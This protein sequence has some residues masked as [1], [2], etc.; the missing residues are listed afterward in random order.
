MYA[1]N[2]LRYFCTLISKFIWQSNC[3]D[4]NHTC[5]KTS[6]NN[7]L[8]INHNNGYVH[9][10]NT[11]SHQDDLISIW[12]LVTDQTPNVC[13]SFL[14]CKDEINSIAR[15]RPFAFVL[16]LMENACDNELSSYRYFL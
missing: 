2:H 16:F 6:A 9:A 5:K 7:F 15:T 12:L 3:P 13:G 1:S 14:Q 10:C 4:K 8:N 11:L